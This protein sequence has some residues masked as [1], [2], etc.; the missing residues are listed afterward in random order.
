M[1]GVVYQW[2]RQALLAQRSFIFHNTVKS[3]LAADCNRMASAFWCNAWYSL[4][5]CERAFCLYLVKWGESSSAEGV[6]V[7][8][9]PD[10]FNLHQL[11]LQRGK[12]FSKRGCWQWQWSSLHLID[13]LLQ[14]SSDEDVRTLPP[15]SSHSHLTAGEYFTAGMPS[16]QWPLQSG[17]TIPSVPNGVSTSWCKSPK[18]G[19]SWKLKLQQPDCP[20]LSNLEDLSNS[21][22]T[23]KHAKDCSPTPQGEQ[24]MQLCWRQWRDAGRN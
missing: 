8:T 15:A 6:G 10:T 7:S 20:G 12:H 4:L 2:L 19:A 16:S 11:C 9:Q 3:W 5:T 23:L 14:S 13:I 17:R 24:T 22:S 18:A 1:R 21:L